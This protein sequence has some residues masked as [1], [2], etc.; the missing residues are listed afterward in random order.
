MTPRWRRAAEA[1]RYF[2]RHLGGLD[3]SEDA[4]RAM[5]AYESRGA[6]LADP[7]R[8][9]FYVGKHW[10]DWQLTAWKE[11]LADGTLTRA[12]L[13]GYPVEWTRRLT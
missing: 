13:S 12:E 9:G 8:N 5:F 1:Y 3:W 10:F 11:G 2:G 4:A 7:W 6:A